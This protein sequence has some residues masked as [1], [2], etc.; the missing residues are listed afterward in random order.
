MVLN[1]RV[2]HDFDPGDGASFVAVR[3][4]G[5]LPLGRAGG[6]LFLARSLAV[7]F[8]TMTV[9][10]VGRHTAL[11]TMADAESSGAKRRHRTYVS[12]C[13]YC[14]K[15]PEI[16]YRHHRYIQSHIP[17]LQPRANV[18]YEIMLQ[19]NRE[20]DHSISYKRPISPPP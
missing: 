17:I 5:C 7:G 18:E 14:T 1:E 2:R 4:G 15:A 3:G 16:R 8:L 6:S 13:M 11:L 12:I 19:I 20:E 9:F 10:G